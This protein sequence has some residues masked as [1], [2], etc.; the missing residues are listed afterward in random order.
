MCN[1]F[2][3]KSLLIFNLLPQQVK[4]EI[5]L[6]DLD[7]ALA[8]SLYRGYVQSQCIANERVN[9]S[10]S[11]IIPEEFTSISNSAFDQDVELIIKLI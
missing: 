6:S 9:H 7:T 5:K 3:R 10:D 11:V 8:D 2:T 4:A 1:E